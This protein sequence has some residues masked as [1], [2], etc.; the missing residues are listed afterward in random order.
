MRPTTQ[1]PAGL[2]GIAASPIHKAVEAV[3]GDD[4]QLYVRNAN[5]GTWQPI[6]VSR[7]LWRFRA[8]RWNRHGWW[9]EADH[10]RC[11]DCLDAE[12]TAE[13]NLQAA[14]DIDWSALD[15]GL[16]GDAA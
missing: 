11:A 12:L 13:I 14:A 15:L 8:A 2:P 5:K 1:L 7:E 9:C 16:G 10:L 3:D 4:G 6:K